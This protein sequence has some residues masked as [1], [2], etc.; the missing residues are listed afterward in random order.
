MKQKIIII[1]AGISGLYLA[2]LLEKKY[3]VLIFE[4][5][6]RVGGRVFS[7]DGHDLGPSWI[8]SHHKQ[9]LK[10]INSLGLELFAQHTKGHALY[11]TKER[12]ELFD[13]PPSAPSARIKGSLASLINALHN[14]LE[15][16]KIHLMQEVK[17]IEENG[18][19][20]RVKTETDLYEADYVISTLPPRLAAAL[21]YEPKLPLREKEKMLATQTWMGNSAKCVIEFKTAFWREKSLSGFVFSNLGP[22]SEIHDACIENRAA[23]FGFLHSHARMENIEK[24]I[25][26]QLIRLFGISEDEIVKIHLVDWKREQFTSTHQDSAPL[27]IHPSYGIDT[28]AYS[29]KI[30]F[31]STEFSFEEGGYLEGAIAHATK[32]AQQLL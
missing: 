14:S 7:I 13:A 6:D 2:S 20:V 22:M 3:E 32:I 8:W 25:T 23:L 29:Q 27:R 26:Q 16:T 17:S 10:L 15:S 19:C 21:E 11:D 31:S 5:R 18:S 12:V 4:A 9:M 1:G 30:L 24:N 28:T